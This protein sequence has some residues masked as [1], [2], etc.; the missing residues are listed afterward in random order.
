LTHADS[1]QLINNDEELPQRPAGAK[2]LKFKPMRGG[3]AVYRMTVYKNVLLAS[4]STWGAYWYDG[5]KKQIKKGFETDL[6]A[7]R[8]AAAR[9]VVTPPGRPSTLD[10]VAV[11]YDAETYVS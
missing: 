11:A 1:A 2:P 5:T 6:A 7:A 3:K 8:H 9:H 4:A 10:T